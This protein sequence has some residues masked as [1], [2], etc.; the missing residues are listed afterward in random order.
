VRQLRDAAGAGQ[1]VLRQLRLGGGAVEGYQLS[2]I[3]YLLSA[4]GYQLTADG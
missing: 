2:A 4:I 3:G 1:P